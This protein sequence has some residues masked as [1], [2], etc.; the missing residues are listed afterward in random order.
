M[1]AFALLA[2]AILFSGIS[3]GLLAF[4]GRGFEEE[5]EAP[6][7]PADA[8]EN[9][10]WTFARFHFRSGKEFGGFR[11][12]QLWAADYPKADRQFT[13]GVR[14]LTRL[15][16]RGMEQV[17]DADSGD[18]FNWP[19]IYMEH[20]AG[21]SLTEDEAARLRQYLLRGGFLLSDDTHGIYEW[22]ALV[23]GLEMILPGRPIEDLKNGDEIFHVMYDLDE[24]FQIHGTRFLWGGR[25]YSPDM[26]APKWRAI[27]DD[28]GRILVAICHNSDVGDAWEWADSPHFPE[29]ETSLA[30]R[31]GINYILFDMTH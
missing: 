5:D 29:R 23:R 2:I 17:V 7:L 8:H 19:W 18:L 4:Q 6:P 14:R 10:E 13:A 22:E 12:F 15:Q 26:V 11:R 21:W 9:A 24:K 25:P 1:K 31:I 28:Q 16:A 27:R 30:Y 20:G 3:A